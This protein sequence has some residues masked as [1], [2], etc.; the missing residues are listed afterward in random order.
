MSN[1]HVKK[2]YAISALSVAIKLGSPDAGRFWRAG[3]GSIACEKY[4]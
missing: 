3:T 2:R 1:H 4:G